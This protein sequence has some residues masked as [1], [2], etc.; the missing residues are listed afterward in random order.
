M[1]CTAYLHPHTRGRPDGIRSHLATFAQGATVCYCSSL[2]GCPVCRYR[3]V[4]GDCAGAPG[5]EGNGPSV[6][7]SP[8]PDRKAARASLAWAFRVLTSHI[9]SLLL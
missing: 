5:L 2:S 3:T 9:G 7:W 1:E 6:P 4:A 8:K